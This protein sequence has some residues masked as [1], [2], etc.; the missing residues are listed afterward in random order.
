MIYD[1]LEGTYDESAPTVKDVIYTGK[2]SF[3]DIREG[4]CEDVLLTIKDESVDSFI[5]D[6]PYGV[7]MDT[8]DKDM[9]TT[10]IWNLCY[11]KLKYGGHI[12]IFC[13]PSMV[14]LLCERMSKTEFE[15]RDQFIWCTQGTHI[16]GQQTDDG[17]YGSK[18]RNVYNPI[19]L[20]R[21]KIIGSELNNWGLYRTNLLNLEDTRQA[22]KGNHSSII[23]KFEDTGEMHYQSDTKSNTF[24]KLDKKGWIPSA[25]GSLPTNVQYCPRATRN[26]KTVNGR[27]E[28]T[29][30]SVKPL[31]IL[32]WLVKLLTNSPNQLVADIYCGTGSLGVACRKL[33]RQFLG[34][35]LDPTNVEIAKFRIKHTFDLA[36]KY[37]EKAKPL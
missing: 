37:F 15:F 17:A 22:Y 19:L 4:R 34:V 27:I 14:P 10:E 23:K 3:Y 32:C 28:N 7:S 18:I 6:P 20:Y 9:P 25:R 13:Q 33:N 30:V 11:S 21:K 2:G 12:A 31:G 24:K 1:F 36:D 26:E 29:H 35:E 8:W 5:I 16:K